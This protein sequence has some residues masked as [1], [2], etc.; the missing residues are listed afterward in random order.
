MHVALGNYYSRG[1]QNKQKRPLN[2]AAEAERRFLAC[3]YSAG[4]T[5]ADVLGP[6][7]NERKERLLAMEVRLAAAGTAAPLKARLR[8]GGCRWEKAVGSVAPG[9]CDLEGQAQVSVE[10]AMRPG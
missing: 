6:G 10:E 3:A 1:K 4:R 7:A 2:S 9:G 8:D 5:Q